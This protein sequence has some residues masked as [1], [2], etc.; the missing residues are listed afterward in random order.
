[1]ADNEINI[2]ISTKTDTAPLEEL[3]DML[4]DIQDNADIKVEVEDGSISDATDKTEEDNAADGS[5]ED[6]EIG[7]TEGRPR[8]SSR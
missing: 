7:G 2:K 8:I 1:M 4:E 5:G 6:N 3:S